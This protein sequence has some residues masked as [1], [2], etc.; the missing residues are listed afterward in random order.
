VASL[1]GLTP[2][3]PLLCG[4][5]HAGAVVLLGAIDGW[6]EEHNLVMM[7]E[8]LC[9]PNCVSVGFCPSVSLETARNIEI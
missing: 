3:A 9:F 4:N 1:G 2:Y 5:Y 7:H 8:P 6:S